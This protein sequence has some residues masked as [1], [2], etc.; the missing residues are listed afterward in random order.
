MLAEEFGLA[1]NMGDIANEKYGSHGMVL[2][3]GPRHS[4]R[5]DNHECRSLG[6][7]QL[8]HAAEDHP[9]RQRRVAVIPGSGLFDLIPGDFSRGFGDAGGVGQ[10]ADGLVGFPLLR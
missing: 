7:R 3:T 10:I 1:L 5:V 2:R 8:R 6:R 4:M 9:R